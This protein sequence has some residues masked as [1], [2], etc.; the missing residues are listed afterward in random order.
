MSLFSVEFLRVIAKRSVFLLFVFFIFANLAL[1]YLSEQNRFHDN[2]GNQ[3]FSVDAYR[4]LLKDLQ[5]MDA[6]DR[7]P[8]LHQRQE[9]LRAYMFE[10]TD[11]DNAPTDAPTDASADAPA[12]APTG[13]GF[14]LYAESFVSESFL[15]RAVSQEFEEANGYEGYL[16]SV[17]L[18]ADSLSNSIFAGSDAF[19]ENN[20]RKTKSDYGR[21][22]GI[23]VTWDIRT[24]VQ[25]ATEFP[26]TDIL[27]VLSILFI[28]LML[29][30]REKECQILPL[31]KSTRRGRN[32]LLRTKYACALCFTLLLHLCMSAS[33]LWLAAGYYGLGDVTRSLQSVYLSASL[34]IAVWQYILL[35]FLVRLLVYSLFVALILFICVISRSAVGV[36]IKLSGLLAVSVVLYLLIPAYSLVNILKYLNL[37]YFLQPSALLVN[38][39]N[40]NLLDTPVN[41][42]PLA[43]ATVLF[44]G[45]VVYASS[46]RRFRKSQP[47]GGRA[48]FFAVFRV[49]CRTI[50]LFS[51]EIWK[52][53]ISCKAILLLLALLCIQVW[54]VLSFPPRPSAAE[55]IYRTVVTEVQGTPTE[56]N[57]VALEREL[58]E[59]EGKTSA[60]SIEK[61]SALTR[62]LARVDYLFAEK[63]EGK[64]LYDT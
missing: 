47:Y 53:C 9:T 14:T 42:L 56:E 10:T 35:V 20:I 24:G 34:P 37:F 29:V 27:M 44:V 60:C 25:M 32:P 43:L 51:H 21:L 13:E 3:M 19:T 16:E 58:E 36:Y 30:T 23:N 62:V 12:D 15:L 6:I 40:I 46:L 45:V 8:F 17:F 57:R 1:S 26:G 11:M 55:T 2:L 61:R 22:S 49:R 48:A 50:R 39:V 28:C 38:Y 4:G 31:L 64:L 5:S 41:L 33:H 59:L 63:P 52:S 7:L 18:K 54:R